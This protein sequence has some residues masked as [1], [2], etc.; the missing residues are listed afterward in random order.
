MELFA[1]P[2]FSGS[3]ADP[4]DD[5]SAGVAVSA[6]VEAEADGVDGKCMAATAVFDAAGDGAE[7]VAADAGVVGTGTSTCT[8]GASDDSVVL[9]PD[10]GE[11][12]TTTSSAAGAEDCSVSALLD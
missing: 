4:G 5:V 10:D 1:A 3:I 6:L 12:D 8:T 2:L 9:V 11:A 7:C